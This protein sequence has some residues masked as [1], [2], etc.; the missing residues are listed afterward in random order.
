MSEKGIRLGLASVAHPQSNGQAERMNQM[1]LAGIKP[2]LQVPLERTPA[3]W[4]DELPAVLWGNRTTPN[5]STG[6]T[7]FFMV[8]E[9]EAV[10]PSDLDNDSPQVGLYN[11]EENEEARLV[12]IDILEEARELALS[13][14]AIYQ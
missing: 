14:T 7:P 10:M 3:C 5:R 2:Q 6:Y 13:R 4:L 11:E 1:V 8:Y 9:A 12:G